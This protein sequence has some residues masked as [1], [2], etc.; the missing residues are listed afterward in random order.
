VV[1]YANSW[2]KTSLQNT[3]TELNMNTGS[4]ITDRTCAADPIYVVNELKVKFSKRLTSWRRDLLQ[5][6]IVTQL[7]KK[8]SRLL[9]KQKVQYRVRKTPTYTLSWASWNQPTCSHIFL[10]IIF[11]REKPIGT[12]THRSLDNIKN[13][14]KGTYYYCANW[15][16]L[17]Q[18][19]VQWRTLVNIWIS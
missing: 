17:A 5:K 15:I 7:L 4:S 1:S 13:N 18:N 8:F 2:I 16:H 11:W 12:L 3:S 6:Q 14:L 10:N 19:R 9:W